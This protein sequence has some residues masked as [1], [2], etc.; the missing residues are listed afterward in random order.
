MKFKNNKERKIIIMLLSILNLSIDLIGCLST[1]E[2]TIPYIPVLDDNNTN[3]EVDTNNDTNTNEEVGRLDDELPE[4]EKIKPE[5][6]KEEEAIIDNDAI[7]DKVNDVY[8]NEL[9]EEF[10]SRIFIMSN[11]DT[12]LYNKY[13]NIAS[14]TKN[15]VNYALYYTTTG[16]T[17]MLDLSSEEKRLVNGVIKYIYNNLELPYKDEKVYDIRN[18]AVENATPMYNA[19]FLLSL[20]ELDTI[21]T[22]KDYSKAISKIYSDKILKLISFNKFAEAENNTTQATKAVDNEVNETGSANNNTA[23]A[24]SNEFK[25][26]I[27]QGMDHVTYDHFE[28]NLLPFLNGRPHYYGL[29]EGTHN[30]Y[31]GIK[32]RDG[33]IRYIIDFGS[34]TGGNRVSLLVEYR[35]LTSKEFLFVDVNKFPE[36]ATA[37]FA[38]D[39]QY[40]LSAKEADAVR[41]SRI[42]KNDLIYKFVDLTNTQYLENMSEQDI[43]RLE[44]NLMLIIGYCIKIANMPNARFRI[45]GFVNPEKFGVISDQWTNVGLASLGLSNNGIG[46]LRLI[47]KDG[48]LWYPEN[49]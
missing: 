29:Y 17:E 21:L 2:N 39:T 32:G 34:I 28:K 31:I 24:P 16:N 33:D 30:Y 44:A 5:E 41:K 43:N 47:Y 14:D 26:P 49:F 38:S 48:R 42:F 35:G 9:S 15:L 18:F 45:Y 37:I 6:T 3:D 4:E 19:N 23:E 40:I 11:G 8:D 27:P 22:S 7:M 20:K 13:L 36:I 46:N 25:A 10:K 12:N 1:I